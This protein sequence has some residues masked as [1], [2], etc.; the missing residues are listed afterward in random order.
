MSRKRLID[1]AYLSR[2]AETHLDEKFIILN[3]HIRNLDFVV[4]AKYALQRV[5]L[6][7]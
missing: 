1:Y 6:F 5:S 4:D 2:L 3:D 7:S